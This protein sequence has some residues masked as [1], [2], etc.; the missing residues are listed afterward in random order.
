MARSSTLLHD[1]AAASG[2]C[3]IDRAIATSIAALATLAPCRAGKQP[4]E[5]SA[6]CRVGGGSPEI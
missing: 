2:Q 5:I 3:A 4:A 6:P 1:A